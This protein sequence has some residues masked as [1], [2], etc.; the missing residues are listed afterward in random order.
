MVIVPSVVLA[1]LLPGAVYSEV[2]AHLDGYYY[3]FYFNFDKPRGSVPSYNESRDIIFKNFDPN[4]SVTISDI[5]ASMSGITGFTVTIDT[6]SLSL[7]PSE[8]DRIT[9]V[10]HA[11][12]DMEEGEHKGS[13]SVTG[14]GVSLNRTIRVKI[15]WP[16]PS[17]N[18]VW[19][20]ANWGKMKAGSNL[21]QNLVI[22]ETVGYKPVGDVQLTLI[23]FGPANLSYTTKLGTIAPQ[24]TNTIP[25]NINIPTRGLVPTN[26]FISPSLS[27]NGTVSI[28]VKDASYEIPL[29]QLN[30]DTTVLNFDDIT[31]EPGKDSGT[32][33]IVLNE[34]GG[35]T[36]VENLN[37][38]L[39][40]GEVGWIEFQEL[41]YIPPGTSIPV[42]FS[43]KLPSEASLG[44]K[45]W[46]YSL[47]T[48][49]AGNHDITGAVR[50]YF[51]GVEDAI[52]DLDIL[53]LT[54]NATGSQKELLDNTKLLLENARGETELRDIAMVMS[55]YS[56]ARSLT[57]LLEE[58][59]H[60]R[61]T[62]LERAG[63]IV[64]LSN[65]ALTRINIGNENLEKPQLKKYSEICSKVG[66]EIWHDNAVSIVGLI[67]ERAEANKESNYRVA[68]LYYKRG[69]E[70]Y[71]LLDDPKA[72][73]YND[74]RN[75]LEDLYGGSIARAVS[76]RM[77]GDG[78]LE[79]SRS[80]MIK[81]F[82]FYFVVNPFS[83]ELVDR[84]HSI[85]LEKYEE[86]ISLFEVAGEK[87]DADLL[88]KEME[89]IKRAQTI[90]KNA[91]VVYG[92][93][94]VALFV[95]FIIRIS[96]GLQYFRRDETET[97]I[98]EVV[99]SR[100]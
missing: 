89:K 22:K 69:A 21:T 18:A 13:L 71:T 98:G 16:N 52:V 28:E 92:V 84:R 7:D 17:I 35:Y 36:P 19:D 14:T 76:L 29:P 62:D 41:D 61:E 46:K 1:L 59:K 87:N 12:K 68:T 43:L 64:V 65:N 75:Q 9:A 38:S 91:F 99:L 8:S 34:T 58:L 72:E 47:T 5:S 23:E 4:E 48:K 100:K 74:I 63:A 97:H 2:S 70:I 94:W 96:L 32:Q 78:D 82:D 25:I 83:Y 24:S 56:G 6:T 81:V 57:N 80:K 90:F 3:E 45:E 54:L 20:E 67:A 10:F 66:G 39:T 11:S 44:I 37:I 55:V 33:Q 27:V 50:V 42:S 95:W 51:P 53:G 40:S 77:E 60:A 79:E 31:F 49:Y 93:F 88:S 86:A 85:T 30:L 26:Y 15:T 73:E